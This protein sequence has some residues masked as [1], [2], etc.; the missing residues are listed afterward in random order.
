MSK[1]NTVAMLSPVLVFC[2]SDIASGQMRER[3]DIAL[4]CQWKLEDLYASYGG[5]GVVG[6]QQ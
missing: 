6:V 3:S 1:L 5:A 2:L 4:A